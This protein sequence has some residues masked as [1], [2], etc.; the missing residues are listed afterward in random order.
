MS[1][2]S[3]AFNAAKKSG[4]GIFKFNGKYY[5]TM[6]EQDNPDEFRKQH[7]FKNKISFSK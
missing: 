6:T 4:K 5:N 2:F 1:K 3:D 7:Y